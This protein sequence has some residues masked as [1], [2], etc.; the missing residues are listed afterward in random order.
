[1]ATI[2]KESLIDAPL[3]KAWAALSD[4]GAVHEKLVPGFV[5]DC[6]MDGAARVVTF[7]NGATAREL[8]VG[9]DDTA[10]RVAYSATGGRAAH[11]NASA[12]VFDAGENR[13]RFVWITDVLPNDVAGYID[14]MMEQGLAV[15][16]K[17]L[18]R[19]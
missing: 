14:A 7:F 9:I 18:E 8:L 10:N 13:T 1:M 4:F 11:H 6:R 12:Q 2:Y 17:T 15:I 16:K 5:T 3:T 19:G